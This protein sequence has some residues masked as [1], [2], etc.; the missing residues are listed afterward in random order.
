MVHVSVLL[1]ICM[2]VV[3]QVKPSLLSEVMCCIC[4]TVFRSHHTCRPY[5]INSKIKDFLL[6]SLNPN[7]QIE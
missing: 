1:A 7:F 5:V 6:L 4:S 2:S 3:F